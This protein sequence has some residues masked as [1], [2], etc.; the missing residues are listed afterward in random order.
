MVYLALVFGENILDTSDL[1]V[2][3]FAKRNFTI[4]PGADANV[5][6]DSLSSLCVDC[7]MT[8]V[9]C[10]GYL[11]P[12]SFCEWSEGEMRERKGPTNVCAVS[13]NRG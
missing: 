10:L 1:C 5:S 12:G 6:C 2:I 4:D 13:A 7:C 8:I 9:N 11:R 3:S